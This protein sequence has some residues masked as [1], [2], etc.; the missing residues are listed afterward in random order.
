MNGGCSRQAALLWACSNLRDF[1]PAPTFDWLP[2]PQ[3]KCRLSGI[4][5]EVNVASSDS[6]SLSI[7]LPV[8]LH[9]LPLRYFLHG[10]YCYPD[11]SFCSS[12]Y[13]FLV[14]LLLP[15]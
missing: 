2:Q 12:I 14:C 10:I 3:G 7:L 9:A 15:P 8:M 4:R 13:F 5:Q 6:L 1:V 11:L